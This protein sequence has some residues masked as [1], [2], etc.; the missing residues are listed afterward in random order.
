ML[1]LIIITAFI[2]R[3]I[4]LNQ[5]LWLDE[6]IN[7]LATQK[8]S[9]LGIITEYAKGDFHPPG[10]FIVIW[11][12]AKLF[13]TNEIVVRIP[14]VIFGL[15]TVYIIYLIGQKLHSKRLGL[16]SALLLAINPLHVYYSQ[17][18]R[19]YSLATLVV[20]INILLLLKIIKG[21]KLNLILLII[22]NVGVLMSDYLT[23]FIFPAQ[24]I[25]LLFLKQKEILKKWFIAFICAVLFSIWWL[26]IFITQLSVGSVAA[27]DLPTWKFVVGAFD[28]KTPILTFVK[29]I[30]GRISLSDK[31]LY[32]IILLPVVA[33][34]LFLIW[35]GI[36]TIPTLG[37]YLLIIWIL[38][39]IILATVISFIIPIFSYF[40]M[41]FILPAFIILTSLGITPFKSKPRKALL[42][43]IVLVQLFSTSI[44]LFNSSFHR[45]NW[46][47]LVNFL[48]TQ[49]K[50]SLILFESSGTL[51]PFDYYAK[52]NLNAKG[53]LKDF[54]AKSEADLADIQNF[55]INSKDIYLVN[56]IVEISDPQRLIDKRLKTLGYKISETKDFRGVGFLYH[57]VK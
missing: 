14:S 19:M 6:A 51:P 21:E 32:E 52:D 26:P 33:L 8:Y 38:V 55:S 57:Y 20:S 46:R 22:S 1:F 49:D 13:G 16:I 43:T 36:K 50:T 18:A 39:P 12:W 7:I 45:E 10:Y 30:I 4:S 9:L 56:Y 44:Y 25:L 47:G 27:S 28:I 23:Y 17:E 37:K 3:V 29:F 34:F 31:L 2:L 41:L 35:R 48:K 42:I 24:F 11:I 53:G 15:L 5:S 40:R 54:P